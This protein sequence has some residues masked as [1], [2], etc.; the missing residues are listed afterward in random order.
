M[1]TISFSSSANPFDMPVKLAYAGVCTRCRTRRRR[2]RSGDCKSGVIA[3]MGVTNPDAC[4]TYYP[5]TVKKVQ[6]HKMEKAEVGDETLE[7][8]QVRS[9]RLTG[10]LRLVV[11]WVRTFSSPPA[12][13]YRERRAKRA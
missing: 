3:A 2:F 12:P 9:S 8:S 10:G 6:E 7:T 1:S 5:E 4:R 13:R 11:G